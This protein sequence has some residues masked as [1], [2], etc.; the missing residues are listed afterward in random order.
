M[1]AQR[2]GVSSSGNTDGVS[3]DTI[4]V[5]T[6]GTVSN[7]DLL[8]AITNGPIGTVTPPAGWVL[9]GDFVDGTAT[10]SNM[11]KKIASSEPA[12][13]TFTFPSSSACRVVVIDFVGAHDILTWDARTTGTDSTPSARSLGAARDAIGY[14][15]LCWSDSASNTVTA[16]QGVED[17]DFNS[18]NTGSTIYRG[19]AGYAYGPGSTTAFSSVN[20]I[21]NTGDFLPGT[22]FTMSGAPTGAVAWEFLVDAKAPDA[23]TWSSTN[24]AFDVELELDRPEIDAL[25]RIS[26]VFKGDVT[27]LV[28]AFTESGESA[29]DV[30]ENLAD[31]LTSTK[32]LVSG[33]LGWVQYDFGSGNTKTIRRYRLTSAADFG[34]RD[35]RDWTL[36][37]SNNGTDYTVLDTRT[38][39]SFASRES[40]AE[41]RVASPGSYR[42]YKLDITSNRAPSLASS[43][44][45]AEFRLSTHDAWEDVTTYVQEESKIRVTRGLQG[46]SG[47]HDF[48]RAYCTFKNTDGRFSVR[49]QAGAYYG[50]IQRNTQMR[51]SKAY[52]T[53]QLQ[54]QGAVRLEGTNMSGDCVRTTL[55]DAL[56]IAGD[57]DIRIDL[58]PESWRDEQ[59]L[60]GVSHAYD[61]TPNEG[62][63][64]RI[65]DAG[66]L[67]LTWHDGTTYW[68]ISSEFPVPRTTARL[69]VR[70][71]L[72]VDNGASGNT[73]TFYTSDSISGS[74]TQLGDAITSS[75]TTSI[76]YTGGALCVGHVQG[77]DQRG[78]HGLVYHF[79]LRTGIAGT[80]VSDIDFTALANGVHQFDETSNRWITVN[81][82]VVSNRRYRFHGEVA[83]WPLYWDPTGTWVEVSATGAGIQK[84]LERGSTQE[85]AYRR[86]HTKGII[87]DPGAF[88]RFAEPSAYWP[89]EDKKST[90]RIASGLS[91]KPH[92]EVYGN[93]EFEA[94]SDF[95]GSDPIPSLKQSKLGGR[96]SGNASGYA[97]VR[98]LMFTEAAITADAN[99]VT[100]Y[101]SGSIRKW[102]ID[103]QA[104]NTWRIRGYSEDGLE[105]G[106][107]TVSAT[108][109]SVTTVNE[110][111]SVRIVLDQN[112]ADIDYTVDAYDPYGGDLGGGTG[113]FASQT[114][115]RVY[116]V[117]V[118]D[119]DSVKMNEVMFGHLA[120][121]D[122]VD[123]PS[124]SNPL[125][126]H[127]YETAA[128]RAKR[129]CDEEQI[130]YR[131]VGALG[132]SAML[133]FQDTEA[134]FAI[135]STGAVSDDGYLI[136]PLDAFGIEYRTN[137][138]LYNQPAHL[139]LD[140]DA[141]ELSGE[142]RP[143]TDDAHIVNDFT[144]SRGDAGSARFRREDG[145]LSVSNPP[146]GVG[147]Y[148]DSQS[149]SFA[150]EGQCVQMASWQVHKGTLD[151]ERYPRIQ[152]ALEN[153]RIAADSTLVEGILTLDVGKRVD[154]T[155]TPDFLPEEDIRQIVIGYEEWFDN[156]QHN[157]SLNTIPERIFEIAEYDSGYSFD[158][159]D[160]ELYQD[161]SAAATSVS[162][163]TNTGLK[164][165]E[166]AADFDVL[167]D[168]ERMTATAV[169]LPSS[170]YSSDTFNRADSTTNLGSTDGGTVSAWTQN[171]GTWGIN[172][173]QA[174]I[175]AAATSVATIPMAADLEEVSVEVPVWASG[176]AA[177][178]FRFTDT[179]NYIWW[180]GTV[181]TDATLNI[182][183]GG[184]T[185]TYTPDVNESDFVL[186]AGDKLSARC[187]GSV[188]EVFRNDILALTISTTTN[189]TA[190]RVGMRLTTTAPRLENFYAEQVQSLQTF[191]VTRGVGGSTAR[192][193]KAGSAVVLYQSPYRGL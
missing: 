65:D 26:S 99:I 136:D 74:W 62:W 39:E 50:S 52:G 64:L 153:L 78:I 66:V 113:T 139:S 43:V 28:T 105:S 38:N 177:V 31:G 117:N 173:N 77:R 53:K 92:M 60:C 191:T 8:V 47:R 17:F 20:D 150:H 111:M 45:L 91:G 29:P 169:A 161:I 134:P 143:T 178:V 98:F 189:E 97:D 147:E 166:D 151:E 54:L 2:H 84:R 67:H 123:A 193:H 103:Y 79:E 129:I 130:E 42:Y 160:A 7:G 135:M 81:N 94:Y 68:D 58:H 1:V 86:F 156:F 110:Q 174:Y 118:N 40:T 75:G 85:S 116:R 168:G 101:S 144:A 126:A 72:D 9:V 27:G 70:A 46:A 107:A 163:Q 119:D 36:Q 83:E 56:S 82:A 121:Y 69:A 167:I 165:S 141:G 80:L 149:Y 137:R 57:I 95:D 145:P 44:H 59:M 55:T 32:W 185:T 16:N 89:M 102:E 18:S 93:P 24:G 88:E 11:Y 183:S 22:T 13:Y 49:N 132:E 124:I 162:V 159:E 34:V 106:T 108:G 90:I 5:T 155:D 154:I 4:V 35:P 51:V 109:I 122:S 21:V 114:L 33:D 73:V 179:S 76:A 63:S 182:V 184:A 148:A 158:A 23:E 157:F 48:S 176:T 19:Y 164:W 96:V 71:T 131:Y 41:Y 142:L 112:S 3:T 188:V 138:S 125:R 6:P 120:L 181:G 128:S 190:T 115:G 100:F 170:A 172:S 10:Q 180:G 175:S 152:I 171:S 15:V 146:D 12:S 61:T 25:G 192:T 127:I 30:T 104:A 37:G 14:M 186:A 133:G 140:Y 87:P 187:N